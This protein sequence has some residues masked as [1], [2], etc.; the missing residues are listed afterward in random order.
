MNSYER[1][2][3]IILKETPHLENE[4]LMNMPSL[5]YMRDTITKHRNK[6]NHS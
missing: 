1:P 5:S 6:N 4:I 2:M 3:D